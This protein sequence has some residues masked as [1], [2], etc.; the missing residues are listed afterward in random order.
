MGV[1]PMSPATT[2]PTS[3]G[4]DSGLPTVGVVL[5]AQGD[6]PS[7]EGILGRLEPACAEYGVRL[8]VVWPGLAA[9]IAASGRTE[10]GA[11][12][13]GV[14]PESSPA[15]RRQAAAARMDVDIMLFFDESRARDEPWADVLGYRLGI[16]RRGTGDRARENWGAVLTALGVT[17]GGVRG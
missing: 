1:S 13:V 9:A 14:P 7:L 15:E 3:A 2:R 12:V 11:E 16:L 10:A 4:E 5:L 6:R 17:E 8:L